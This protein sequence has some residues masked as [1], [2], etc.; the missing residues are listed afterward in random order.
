M[1]TCNKCKGTRFRKVIRKNSRTGKPYETS[2]CVDCQYKYTNK[3]KFW[4]NWYSKNKEHIR[5]YQRKYYGTENRYTVRNSKHSKH[6]KQRTFGDK[7]AITEFYRNTP[8]G[9]EVDH[10]IPLN[11]K[12][13][14]GLH[15][16]S[17]L[18]YLTIHDNRV[19][20]NKV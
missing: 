12:T 4:Y 15:T 2:R 3:K 11:G 20:S 14:N 5:E 1:K 10:I 16:R 13:V 9:Y 19:K 18:Q 17:N 6:L 8:K 7:K